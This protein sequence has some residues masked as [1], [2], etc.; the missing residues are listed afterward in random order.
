VNELRSSF[1]SPHQTREPREGS[2]QDAA[3][4]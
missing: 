1:Q 2:V 3:H 4:Q